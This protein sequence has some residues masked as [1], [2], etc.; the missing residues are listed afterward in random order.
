MGLGMLAFFVYDLVVGILL[1]SIVPADTW[2]K[3]FDS[4]YWAGCFGWPIDLM[5]F[6][7]G[8]DLMVNGNGFITCGSNARAVYCRVINIMNLIR[9]LVTY[10]G[11]IVC[12]TELTDFCSQV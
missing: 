10:I 4:V 12:I 2:A 1:V 6:I 11:A 8:I 3:P 7:L 9:L 5:V